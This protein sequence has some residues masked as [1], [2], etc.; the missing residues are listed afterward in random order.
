MAVAQ[1]EKRMIVVVV[2][3]PVGTMMAQLLLCLDVWQ[4]SSMIGERRK[5]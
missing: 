1:W 2:V 5:R 3:Q 4:Q